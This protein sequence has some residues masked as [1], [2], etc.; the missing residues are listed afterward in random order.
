MRTETLNRSQFQN[1]K[2]SKTTLNY[3]EKLGTD[4]TQ[5]ERTFRANG[6]GNLDFFLAHCLHSLIEQTG[7]K[8]LIANPP[9]FVMQERS[10]K[11]LTRRWVHLDL[12]LERKL[13]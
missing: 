1:M 4:T 2:L 13:F 9:L 12:P 5:I 8:E 7:G 11:F 3:L 10:P 6:L